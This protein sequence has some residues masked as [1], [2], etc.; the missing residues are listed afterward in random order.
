[1]RATRTLSWAAAMGALVVVMLAVASCGGGSEGV[2][3]GG[4]PGSVGVTLGGEGEF[5]IALSDESIGAGKV[6]F[7]I[8][9]SG[10]IEH[11]F[12][13]VKSDAAPDSFTIDKK[14]NKA[15]VE[16]AK[17]Q[18]GEELEVEDI[19]PG[20]TAS[21][22]ADLEPGKYVFICNIPDHYAGGM[23]TGFTVE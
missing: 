4:G 8:T 17:S 6:T 10:K 2:A 16:A 12:E 20:A 19:E 7:T 13:I 5:D 21:L 14:E 23:H 3:D 1:M 15:V 22:L 9:N 11:E 18:D